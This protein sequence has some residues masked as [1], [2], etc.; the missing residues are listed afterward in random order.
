MS[1]RSS[2]S[3]G[4]RER[5][6]RI[7]AMQSISSRRPLSSPSLELDKFS[8]YHP[9][10]TIRTTRAAPCTLRYDIN[11]SPRLIKLI[12]LIKV[13]ASRA[14]GERSQKMEC[15]PL[16]LPLLW[17]WRCRCRCR[18]RCRGSATR[19]SFRTHFG[20]FRVPSPAGRRQKQN[21]AR[22]VRRCLMVDA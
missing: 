4:M 6:C 5:G 2:A 17:R 11:I 21:L 22:A 10:C 9:H 12:K 20:S 16:P 15:S 8:S 3:K 13:Q 18:C 1:E 7:V 14:K 19:P